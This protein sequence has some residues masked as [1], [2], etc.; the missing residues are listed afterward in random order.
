M[1]EYESIEQAVRRAERVTGG[2]IAMMI[3]AGIKAGLAAATE[4]HNADDGVT[5]CVHDGTSC[6]RCRDPRDALPCRWCRAIV[7]H[8][9][10]CTAY[11]E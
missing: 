10:G 3:E 2:S 7:G 8:N 5:G 6:D 4:P 1:S 11:G 9:V